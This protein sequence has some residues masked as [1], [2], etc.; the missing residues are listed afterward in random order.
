MKHE[1]RTIYEW[2]EWLEEQS[3]A[4]PYVAEALDSIRREFKVPV[5]I[6][7]LTA[8]ARSVRQSF[9][10]WQRTWD[11]GALFQFHLISPSGLVLQSSRFS[12]DTKKIMRPDLT[13]RIA[14]ADE[15]GEQL[16]FIKMQEKQI[17]SGL[18]YT[19]EGLP[20]ELLTR[21]AGNREQAKLGFATI[22]IAAQMSLIGQ[23][24][25]TVV[26]SPEMLEKTTASAFRGNSLTVELQ[27]AGDTY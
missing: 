23:E 6:H 3:Q 20:Q 24:L 8:A 27:E 25:R 11:T 22:H 15:V 12:G 7:N 1:T 21:Y 9:D 4:N 2:A 14:E 5:G 17:I 13:G 10:K 18:G 26:T 19:P 16:P